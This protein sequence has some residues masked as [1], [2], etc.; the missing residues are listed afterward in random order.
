MFS[1]H[2][3]LPAARTLRSHMNEDHPTGQSNP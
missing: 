2:L 3:D 1:A